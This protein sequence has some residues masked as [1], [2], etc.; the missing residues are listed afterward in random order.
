MYQGRWSDAFA[1]HVALALIM[2]LIAFLCVFL[3]LS[4]VGSGIPEVKAYLNGVNLGTSF[5]LR[6]V[7]A[8]SFS[9]LFAVS[10]GLFVGPDGPMV[11]VGASLGTMF[12]KVYFYLRPNDGVCPHALSRDFAT[13]GVAAALAA[14]FRAPIGGVLFALEE[15][16]S[17]WSVSNTAKAFACA[18]VTFLTVI[19][20]ARALEF[21]KKDVSSDFSFG[22]FSDVASEY[23]DYYLH[24]LFGFM[25]VG[26]AGGIL[27]AVF[28]RVSTMLKNFRNKKIGN[29]VGKRFAEIMIVSMATAWL[30]FTVP[31]IWSVCTPVP[32][33]EELYLTADEQELV[34]DLVQ[35]NCPYGT[36]NQAASL[37]FVDF[38]VAI[39]MVFHYREHVARETFSVGTLAV[40][41]VP[42]IFVAM[43]TIGV[44]AAAGAFVPLLISG[45][46][47]GRM[48]GAGLT[49]LLPN[50]IADSGTYALVGAAALLG[51]ACRNV[52][53]ITVILMEATGTLQYALPL[54][55]SLIV[56]RIIGDFFSDGLYHAQAELYGYQILDEQI[57]SL[58]GA[59]SVP[60]RDYMPRPVETLHKTELAE[61]L[62]EVLK[63]TTHGMFPVVDSGGMLIGVLYR[64][65]IINAV[66]TSIRNHKQKKEDHLDHKNHAK[67][68]LSSDYDR[69][70]VEQLE[71]ELLAS[72]KG[73][74]I[75]LD[76][77]IDYAPYVILKSATV[78]R[79]YKLFR[80]LGLRH[81]IVIDADMKVLGIV[82][83]SNFRSLKEQGFVDS[84][85]SEDLNS[86]PVVT[87][88]SVS[89][90]QENG[91]ALF[92]P[93]K[94]S[95][96]DSPS[97][98]ITISVKGSEN[99]KTAP[100]AGQYSSVPL[101]TFSE[102]G[103]DSS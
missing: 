68:V 44:T 22:K 88:G 74:T 89:L 12:S 57:L 50:S 70:F 90:K 20:M 17:Y 38:N 18:A 7:I 10:S 26:V 43:Y 83:R 3:E 96:A 32:D 98:Q 87:R 16:S 35:Y 60:I 37:L 94:K 103:A 97:K 9:V 92:S 64:A 55:T 81:L 78:A 86:N 33:S 102:H 40:V 73:R 58:P 93:L 11:H 39:K 82:T 79:A 13:F 28:V 61:H 100:Y 46:L 75:D 41:F 91:S 23:S 56:S 36:Y 14:S 5:R 1:S 4:A 77:E 19:I 45:A 25:L 54:I 101:S 53:S 42:Y 59:D 24:E 29:S 63:N 6:T 66:L 15:C 71:H 34:A 51:G 85:H 69:A 65:A 52:A 72:S 62:I 30:T 95:N 99:K 84:I 2:S 47:M 48:I 49:V 21:R 67:R 27:G 8:K 76:G 80:S 31:I